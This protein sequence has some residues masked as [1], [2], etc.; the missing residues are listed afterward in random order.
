MTE[1]GRNFLSTTDSWKPSV[2]KVRPHAVPGTS[3]QNHAA[4]TSTRPAKRLT[5]A[6][7]RDWP[8]TRPLRSRARRENVT[9]PRARGAVCQHVLILAGVRPRTDGSENSRIRHFRSLAWH[10][11]IVSQSGELKISFHSPKF[12]IDFLD[13]GL[14]PKQPRHHTRKPASRP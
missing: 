10:S 8:R 3:S 7:I 6:D 5:R 13:T 9:S 12:A 2:G 1:S 11:D 4:H 14:F